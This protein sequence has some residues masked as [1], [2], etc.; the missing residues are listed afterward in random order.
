MNITFIGG[1]NMAAALIGGLI[2]KGYAPAS[3]RVV[4][5]LP[6]ARKRL[7]AHY[8]V[9]CFA[10][11]PLA[12]PLGD[13]V[14]LAVK[15]QQMRGA[16]QS[17]APHIK[18][19]LVLSI[20]AGIRLPDLSRWLGG[21]THLARC[22]PNTPALIGLGVSGLYAAPAVSAAQRRQAQS[23]LETVGRVLWMD[24]EDQLD[25]VTAVSGSGP[26]YVFYF[27]EAMQ[28]AAESLGLPPETARDL[29]I[30]TMRGAAELAARTDEPV[31]VLRERVTSKGGTTEKALAHLHSAAVNE[32]II[33]AIAVAAT[34]AAELGDELGRD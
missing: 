30:D 26:A 29:V 22:M 25:T 2:A 1:G 6:E 14:V 11:V 5:M 31:S 4:E 32:A 28:K 18:D 8:G 34:R 20:A 3:I 15:P 19:K 24:E 12:L 33:K 21:S 13:V 10:E 9:E 23:I 16:A 27:I 7:H 17:L